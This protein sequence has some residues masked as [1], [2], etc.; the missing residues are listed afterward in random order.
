MERADMMAGEFNR[1][2]P[3][4]TGDTI[5]GMTESVALGEAYVRVNREP[6]GQYRRDAINQ[7]R[8]T[9]WVSLTGIM[10]SPERAA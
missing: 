10:G 4:L 8:A 1:V 2:N 5:T 3:F 9:P 6:D 7:P